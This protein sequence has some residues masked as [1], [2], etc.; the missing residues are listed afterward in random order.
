MPKHEAYYTQPIENV[1]RDVTDF[2]KKYQKPDDISTAFKPPHSRT[3]NKTPIA[4]MID[5]IFDIF[6]HTEFALESRTSRASLGH[7]PTFCIPDGFSLP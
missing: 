5:Y 3:T 6:A 4:D 2:V 7:P 1:N